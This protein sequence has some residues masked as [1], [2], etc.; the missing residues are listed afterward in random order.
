MKCLYCGHDNIK[1]KKQNPI[2]CPRCGNPY[3][4]V[5]V[6]KLRGRWE[7]KLANNAEVKRL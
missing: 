5:P 2:R 6:R 7:Q 3:G 4:S 1:K